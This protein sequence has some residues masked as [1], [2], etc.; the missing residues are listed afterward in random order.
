[1]FRAGGFNFCISNYFPA[2]M[3]ISKG[4]GRIFTEDDVVWTKEVM[5]FFAVF[6]SDIKFISLWLPTLIPIKHC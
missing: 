5:N 1:M 4:R 2:E 6:K 3:E